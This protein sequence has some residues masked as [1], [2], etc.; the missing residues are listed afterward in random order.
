MELKGFRL[1]G[2]RKRRRRRRKGLEMGE[3]SREICRAFQ[4]IYHLYAFE[5]FA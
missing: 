5:S 4:R 1:G 3:C 2:I